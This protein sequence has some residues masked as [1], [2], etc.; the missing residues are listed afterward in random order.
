MYPVVTLRIKD[1]TNYQY[2]YIYSNECENRMI[3]FCLVVLH[4]FFNLP[5]PPSKF[6][7]MWTG[8]CLLTLFGKIEISHYKLTFNLIKIPHSCKHARK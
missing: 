2:K 1:K 4:F 7:P 5:D 3:D 8:H 6:T